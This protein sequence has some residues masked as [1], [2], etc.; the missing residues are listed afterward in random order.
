MRACLWI[1]IAVALA[2]AAC[3]NSAEEEQKMGAASAAAHEARTRIREAQAKRAAMRREMNRKLAKFAPTEIGVD[4]ARIPTRLRPVIKKL[5]EAARLMD[6]LFLVQVAKENPAWREEIAKDAHLGAT[7]RYFDIMHGPWDRLDENRPFWGAKARPKGAT[8]YPEDLTAKEL[9][10]YI[11]ANPG[12]K[13]ALASYFTV[14]ER[15][16]A[17]LKTVPYSVAYKDELAPAARLLEDAAAASGD[18]RLKKYLTLRAKAFSDNEYRESDMAWMDLG[19]GDI[20][21]VIGPYEVYEDELMGYKAAFEAFV[22]IRDPE[23]SAEL[24]KIKALI[25]QMEKNLPIPKEMRNTKRGQESP[26]SVVHVLYTAGDARKAVQTLAFNLPNDEVVRE[27]KGSKKVMLKNVADAK[28]EKILVPIAREMMRADQVGKVSFR[29]FFGHTL[30]HETAHGLGPGTLE[31]VRDGKK[32]KTGVNAELKDLYSTIEE[33]KADALGLFE[34][35]FLVEK[36][37]HP[38]EMADEVFATFL[39]GF[40]RS[41]RF[42][43]AEAHGKANAIQFNYLLEKGAVVKDADGRYGYDA[44]KMRE[45]VKSLVTEL[46]MIEAKG[47]YAGAKALIDKYGTLPEDV[48]K[49]LASLTDIPTDLQ[50]TF[51][52]EQQMQ[53]W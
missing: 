44:A 30:V 45:G 37:L 8:F 51:K 22:T 11:A 36:K 25:P 10:A 39:G 12:Q 3:G 41:V 6:K 35:L 5:V 32:V 48:S 7:L 27:K 42:G 17:K 18:E 46:L 31:V 47:D 29:A 33:A 20:E 28:Y 23:A 16:G 40:F 24:E 49:K 50:P 2:A 1:A 34:S 52:V 14:V 43:A 21:V 26:I 4:E 13:E 19:D 9:E 38:P 15:D 53:G